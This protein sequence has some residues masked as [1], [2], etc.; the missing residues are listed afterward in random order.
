MIGS[1]GSTPALTT[2]S[3]SRASST[4][5]SPACAVHRRAH[6]EDADQPLQVGD[7]MLEPTA[8]RVTRSSASIDLSAREFAILQLLLERVGEL[9]TRDAI[10]DQVWDGDTDLRSNVIDVHVAGLRA[11]IHRPFGT[12]TI[13]TLRGAGYRVEPDP[14]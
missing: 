10:I 1:A 8:R 5:F 9:V 2:T 7:L 14:Q 6:A 12:T 3:A 11:K 4:S 13:T